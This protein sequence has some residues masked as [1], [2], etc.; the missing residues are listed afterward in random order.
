MRRP[1]SYLKMRVLGA[2][3]NAQGQTIVK[4]I[5][6]TA[7]LKFTDEDGNARSFTWR[8]ISTWYYR[9]KAHGITGVAVK[10]RSDKGTVLKNLWKP[11]IRFCQC[12]EKINTPDL[13]STECA[14]KK[15]SFL[16]IALLQLPFTGL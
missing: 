10:V 4:R 6:N 1:S 13:I 5:K 3:E 11:L 2:I 12:S 14:L 7:K 8:T 15:E 9:Y 16:K